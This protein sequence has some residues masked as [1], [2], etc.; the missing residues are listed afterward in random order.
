ML[1]Y[2]QFYLLPLAIKIGMKPI[3]FWEDDPDDLWAYWDAYQDKLKEKARINNI[4]NFNLGQYILLAIAQCLQFSKHPKK[5]F[6]KKPFELSSDKK[7]KLTQ[8]EYEE[9]RKIQAKSMVER[10]NSLKK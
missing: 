3:Q 5:I 1:D 9:I 2:F 6:P 4:N 8:D 10:F 7:V